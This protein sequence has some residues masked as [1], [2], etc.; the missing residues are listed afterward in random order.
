[1]PKL[2]IIIPTFLVIFILLLTDNIADIDIEELVYRFERSCLEHR[3]SPNFHDEK[4]NSYVKMYEKNPYIKNR[5]L[6]NYNTYKNLHQ[7]KSKYKTRCR[8][9]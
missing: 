3:I 2:V 8:S 5:I 6:K 1:M 4:V 9:M 7:V